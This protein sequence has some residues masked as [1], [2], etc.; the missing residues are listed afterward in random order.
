V[1]S[2][3]CYKLDVDE[4]LLSRDGEK[5]ILEPKVLEVL[6]YFVEHNERYIT[7]AELH[8][9]LWQGRIVSDAAVRRIISKLRILFNDDHK[10]PNYI[11]SLSKK[12]YKLICNIEYID[13]QLTESELS[14]ESSVKTH[15]SLLITSVTAK[16]TALISKNKTHKKTIVLTTFFFASVLLV[17]GVFY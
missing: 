10:D 8:E 13:E 5:V 3:G 16:N 7:M 11:K 17:L 9:N 15:E 4:M 6:L 14:P 1:I 12:G 2:L